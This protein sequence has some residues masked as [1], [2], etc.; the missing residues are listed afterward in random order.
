MFKSI[1]KSIGLVLG[2]TLLQYL[3]ISIITVIV[4]PFYKGDIDSY[5]AAS[6]FKNTSVI[7]TILFTVSFIFIL[8]K[9]TNKDKKVCFEKIFLLFMLGI[10]LSLI[11][12]V[13]R[14]IIGNIK[15]EDFSLLV[16]FATGILGPIFEEYL[17]RG[18]VYSILK[19]KFKNRYAMM[20]TTILFALSHSGIENILY[21]FLIG[22]ILMIIYG[23]TNSLKATS[24]FHIGANV[25]SLLFVNF[26]I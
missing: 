25:M 6:L 7:A 8:R 17:Y 2:T 18:K 20:I 15:H 11:I 21:A 22:S 24:A 23:K 10:L 3:Y 19:E 16:I 4:F 12:H 1:I 5:I 9:F 26:C 14:L 13:I